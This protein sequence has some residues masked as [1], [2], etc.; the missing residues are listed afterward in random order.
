MTT[1]QRAR[2][3]RTKDG[4]GLTYDSPSSL[5]GV[6]EAR[7]SAGF[8]IST[9]CRDRVGDVVMPRGCEPHMDGY[10]KT[11]GVFFCH[12]TNKAPIAL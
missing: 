5:L 3:Y 6:D 11:G 8:V 4:D 10:R 1:A 7:M 9:L 2:K 12:E